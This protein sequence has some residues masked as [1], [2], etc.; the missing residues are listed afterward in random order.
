MSV[1]KPTAGH[2]VLLARTPKS[3]YIL[4]VSTRLPLFP[5][6]LV[7]FPNVQLPLHIFEER[8]RLLI[9]RSVKENSPFGVVYHRGGKIMRV[10]CSAVVS[11]VIGAYDDGR[12]DVIA[13]GR[14]RFAIDAVD[15]SGACLEADV[16]FLEEPVGDDDEALVDRAIALLV[17]YGRYAGIR[18]DRDVLSTL[19]ASQLSFLIAGIDV[20]GPD[21]KQELLELEPAERRLEWALPR[22]A[23]VNSRLASAHRLKKTLNRTVDIDSFMN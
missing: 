3:Q 14:E 7:L 15:D 13:I 9:K 10:G 22:L 11:R 4:P 19:T 21:A 2:L 8:Y 18:L 23:R 5:I 6:Q 16:H 20:F 1:E 12:F 17:S